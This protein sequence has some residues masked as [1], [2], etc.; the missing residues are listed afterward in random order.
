MQ[1]LGILIMLYFLFGLCLWILSIDEKTGSSA[2]FLPLF[3]LWPL[4]LLDKLLEH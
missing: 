3:L 1:V 4:V 2:A